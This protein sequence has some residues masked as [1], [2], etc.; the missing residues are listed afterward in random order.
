MT[1]MV[2]VVIVIKIFFRIK[3]Q[4]SGK[5]DGSSWYCCQC[6]FICWQFCLFFHGWYTL[7]QNS[8][9]T[10]WLP[11]A[12]NAHLSNT[13]IPS[14]HYRQTLSLEY[15]IFWKVRHPFERLVSAYENKVW[16][17]WSSWKLLGFNI[18]IS[19]LMYL[20]VWPLYSLYPSNNNET[21]REDKLLWKVW[22]LIFVRMARKVI[23]LKS[24]TISDCE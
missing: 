8:S 12:C 3:F 10:W 21:R 7:V 2:E 11:T 9:Y 18:F 23:M 4:I 6:D 14:S 22:Y 1:L 16:N 13:V 20:R 17:D 19:A 5:N 15:R 24:K